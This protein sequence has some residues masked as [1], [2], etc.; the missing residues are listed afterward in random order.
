MLMASPVETGSCYI[1]E[2][3]DLVRLFLLDMLSENDVSISRLDTQS[4]V[5]YVRN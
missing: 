5:T 4:G 1:E 3:S 2:A